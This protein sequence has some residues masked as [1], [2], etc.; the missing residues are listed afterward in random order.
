MYESSEI[1]DA[2]QVLTVEVERVQYQEKER[3]CNY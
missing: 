2:F 3:G 1:L